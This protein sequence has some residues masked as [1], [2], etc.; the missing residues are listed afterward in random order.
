MNRRVTA[1]TV[2]FALLASLV[3]SACG[4]KP[5]EKPAAPAPAAPASSQP[6]AAKELDKPKEKYVQFA[7]ATSG[8]TYFLLANAFAN[9][10]TKKL[11]VQGSAVSTPGSPKILEL[12]HKGEADLGIA[13]AG[14]ALDASKKEGQFKG[15]DITKFRSVSYL[16]P[17]VM[18]FVVRKDA[19]IKSLED[20]KGKK[21]AVG[22]VGSATELNSFDMFRA[23]G[24]DYRTKKEFTPEYVS[25]AQSVELMKNKQ[26]VASNMIAALGSSAMLELMTSGD[27]ELLPIPD[28]VVAKMKE[29]SPAWFAYEIAANTYKNQP[30]AVKTFAV[31]NWLYARA[32]AS[33][34]LVYWVLRTIY[35][36]PEDL[37]AAHKV[38]EEITLKNSQNGIVVPLHKGA[39]RYYKEKGALK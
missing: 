34:E 38:T 21:V 19:N 30:K 14:V 31:A 3:L 2:V 35:E 9:L 6:A 7:G 8:G 13:Q 29:F 27:F 28:A 24:I 26:V 20:L 5:A 39:E 32:D 17:N 10:T 36:S 37:K 33:E 4:S 22:A 25:E 23:A 16:Y 15:K 11:G 1:V 18:Q 12:L